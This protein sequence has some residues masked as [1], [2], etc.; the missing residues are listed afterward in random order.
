[1]R[2]RRQPDHQPDTTKIKAPPTTSAGPLHATSTSPSSVTPSSSSRAPFNTEQGSNEGAHHKSREAS[3]R[4]GGARCDF[5]TQG[6]EPY[7]DSEEDAWDG[8][9]KPDERHLGRTA[10]EDGGS[11]CTENWYGKHRKAG[12]GQGLN[13][14]EVCGTIGL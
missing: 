2:P 7:R 13:K 9:R 1:M 6:P 14:A 4:A 12:S 8:H 11:R 5:G 10:G 3:P